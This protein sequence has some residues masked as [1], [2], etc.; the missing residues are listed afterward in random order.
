MRPIIAW[1]LALLFAFMAIGGFI[2]GEA[3]NEWV[4][5]NSIKPSEEKIGEIVEVQ[6]EEKWFVVLIDFPD[7][8]E[9]SNCN[10]Q[11]ASTLIDQSAAKYFNQSVHSN[12]SLEIFYHDRIVTTNYGMADYGHDANGQNDVGRNG[13]DPHTLAEEVATAV[14]DEV[15]WEMFDLNEDGWVDRFLIL[16]CVKPQEDG[17]GSS[18]RIWSHFSMAENV[19]ELPNNMQLAYYSI[20]SQYN[21]NNFGTIIHEMY[22]QFGAADL[23]PVEST[24]VTQS[25]KGVGNWDIMASGNWNGN[26]AWPALPT[27]PTMELIGV[28]RYQLMNL[29]WLPGESCS[30][31]EVELIGLSEGGKSLKIPIADNEFIWIEYRS[32]YG[33]DSRLPGNG[34]LVMQQ[35]LNV[36]S[37]EDNLVNSHPDKP[38]LIVLEADGNQDLV[39]SANEGEQSDLYWDGDKFGYEG[40]EIRNRDGIL[41][42]WVGTVNVNGT[43]VSIEFESENCGHLADVDFPDY[44][45]VLTPDGSIEFSI[46][47][48]TYGGCSSPE[49]YLTSSDGRT[50]TVENNKITFQ[51]SGVV[52]VI[53]VISGTIECDSGTPI[54]LRHNFEILGNVPIEYDFESDIPYDKS[55]VVKIP[56]KAFGSSQET[57]I[58]GVEGALSRVA[59][60]EQVQLISHGSVIELKIDPG[61]L[62]VENML[63]RGQ[64]VL[65]TDSGENYYIN[66]ELNAIDEDK[67][68]NEWNEPAVLVPVA[69]LLASLW[70]ILGI[71][72][73]TR[74]VSSELDKVPTVPLESDDPTFIDAFREPYR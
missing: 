55:S 18:S 27:S 40:I 29:N 56:V 25:W 9:S 48:T 69:L 37:V 58:V 66:V 38:W 17:G 28:D 53:G 3:I 54:N 2:N 44:T 6:E 36:G 34:I 46:L 72:S 42:D 73:S 15:D 4:E 35:D 57:W 1:P 68:F 52:G 61:D 50:I 26:G 7:Q 22:H 16:H 67:K 30:G 47:S 23:Y 24:T 13:V 33:F 71:D 10:Q 5:S 45:S 19:V 59:T 74:Q 62:L 64:V 51:E 31:P 21:S 20:A 32:D 63:I 70:V 65:A 8:T 14:S 39:T 43:N 41:V 11:R 60:T 12:S 49:Y